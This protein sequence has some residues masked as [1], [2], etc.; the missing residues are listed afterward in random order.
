[1]DSEMEPTDQGEKLPRIDVCRLYL[2]FLSARHLHFPAA[3]YLVLATSVGLFMLSMITGTSYATAVFF[4]QLAVV[5][6]E[7]AW[8]CC[9]RPAVVVSVK[10]R[11]NRFLPGMAN[12]RAY[13]S[14]S[15]KK[16][17]IIRESN[18]IFC[19]YEMQQKTWVFLSTTFPWD[20]SS[21]YAARA[22]ILASREHVLVFSEKR[23]LKFAACFGFENAG[24]Q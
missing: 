8:F 9:F 10:S 14:S 17:K 23:A 12:F 3:V 13:L 11:K 21:A 1:M 22:W 20:S 5:F 6:L 19:N 2:F 15:P 4:P 18:D 24:G 16:D 7:I